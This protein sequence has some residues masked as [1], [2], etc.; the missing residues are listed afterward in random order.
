MVSQLSDLKDGKLPNLQ[1]M[2]GGKKR[3]SC[4]PVRKR[5]ATTSVRFFL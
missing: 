2:E 5:I 4:T 1:N 3:Q